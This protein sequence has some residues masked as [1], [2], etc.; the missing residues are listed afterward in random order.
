[1]GDPLKLAEVLAG[2]FVARGPSESPCMDEKPDPYPHYYRDDNFRWRVNA[3]GSI[4]FQWKEW[5][6]SG[7]TAKDL[8]EID[9]ISRCTAEE[10][11]DAKVVAEKPSPVAPDARTVGQ[12]MA[13]E[14]VVWNR[15]GYA[16][17]AKVG[18]LWA[19]A[20]LELCDMGQARDNARDVLAALIDRAV[21]EE[22]E[23][24]ARML[25][26]WPDRWGEGS[27]AML[28]RNLAKTIRDR[29]RTAERTVAT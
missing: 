25:D 3:N 9:G 8:T 26:E 10:A 16:I 6:A 14:A 5:V 19:K 23:A 24:C 15:D 18:E 1:M 7:F 29:G 20:K 11:G 17:V 4:D 21:A 28:V 22:R 27:D 2:H 12:R 13:E